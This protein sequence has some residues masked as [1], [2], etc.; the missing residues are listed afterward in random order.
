MTKAK[1]LLLDVETAPL[2]SYTWSIW[3]QNIGLNQIKNDWHVLAVAAKWLGD[4]ASK[5]V[6]QDQRNAKNIE[7]D[8]KLL[9]TIWKLIDEADVLITQ[10]G[11]AFD[12]KKLNARFILNN[13]PPPSSY[14]HIDTKQIA[15]RKFGFTSNKLEY[16]TDKLCNK[17]KKSKHKKFSGFDLWRECLANN[18]KAWNEMSHYNKL[19]VLSLEELYLKLRPW[20]NTVNFNLYHDDE[21]IICSCGGEDFIKKGFAFTST[22]KYQR[23]KCKD[24]GHETRDTV[25]LFSK[26]KRASLRR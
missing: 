25:N 2:L 26:E 8:T 5:I 11:K 12:I 22:G 13:M 3:D 14:K 18:P 9:R 15:S 10:N 1:I 6:Y 20:D 24:C 7:D 19:D 17:F 4:P 16:L 23:F 21:D